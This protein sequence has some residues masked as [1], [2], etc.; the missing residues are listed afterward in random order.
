MSTTGGLPDPALVVLVGASG[1]GKSTWAAQRYRAEEVVSSDALRGVVGSGPHDLDASA[2][3]FDILDRV[4]AA[5]L[6]RGLTTVVDT[7]GLDEGRRTAWCTAARDAGLPAVVVLL[8]TPPDV[9]RR[10]NRARDRPVP[11]PALTAQLGK[12]SALGAALDLE[13]WDIVQ[14]VAG[15][16]DEPDGI[17]ERPDR[18]TGR[19]DERRSSQGLRFVL[20]VS[21]FPW[22]EAPAGWLSAVATAA[23]EAGFAGLALMDHLIQIPQVGRAW[24]PIPEPW[25]TLGLLAGLDT[26]LELGTLVTPVTFRAPGITAKAAATLDA[27]SGGRAFVGLGAGWWERE[28]AAYGLSFPP[29]RE[30]LDDVEAAIATMR[31][32]WAPGTKA[33]AGLPETTG[34]PRPAHDIPIILGGAGARTLRIARRLADGVNVATG[35]VDRAIAALEGTDVTITVLDLP[36]IGRDR[37]D[38]WAR[39]ERLRGSTPAAAYAERTHAGTPGQQRDRYGALADRGVDTVFVAL[40]DLA[41]AADLERLAPLTT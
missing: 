10:R 6:R 41:D 11:A 15:P 30:R 31:A 7:L 20:Q 36:T 25:V 13:G 9:C 33:A 14:R 28:H 8:D 37:E 34:Y 3:A 12:V 27:L 26:G 18:P 23:D 35:N 39:V 2:E 21:R 38:T 29:A 24:E 19:R 16:G 22:G 1:S 17:P 5:R 32:L 40:A 4:V